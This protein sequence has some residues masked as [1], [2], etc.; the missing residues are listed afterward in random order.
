[1]T[2]GPNPVSWTV[3]WGNLLQLDV[4]F[5]CQL[6]CAALER[7]KLHQEENILQL[8]VGFGLMIIIWVWTTSLMVLTLLAGL[9]FG[10]IFCNWM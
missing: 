5:G 3:L 10:G 7:T 4:D 2:E 9:C 8:D 1:M 6:D